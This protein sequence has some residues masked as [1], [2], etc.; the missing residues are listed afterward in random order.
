MIIAADTIVVY[1]TD[2]FGSN[3]LSGIKTCDLIQ[4]KPSS[5]DD[6]KRILNKLSGQIHS[7]ITCVSLFIRKGSCKSIFGN[8]DGEFLHYSFHEETNI[9]FYKLN[10]DM[11]DEYISSNEGM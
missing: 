3:D 5:K 8:D 1:S 6:A 10:N 7:V 11:I 4:E 9:E 2:S